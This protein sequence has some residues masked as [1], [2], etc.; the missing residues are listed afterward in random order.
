MKPEEIYG[1]LELSGGVSDHNRELILDKVRSMYR[2]IISK[3]IFIEEPVRALLKEQDK[4]LELLEE[5]ISPKDLLNY[6][7]YMK[8]RATFVGRYNAE[9]QDDWDNNVYK[10]ISY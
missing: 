9:M 5:T 3:K 10:H 6:H 1:A 8:D 7:C 2:N 4:L